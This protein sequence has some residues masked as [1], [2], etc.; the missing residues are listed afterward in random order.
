MTAPRLCRCHGKAMRF[1]GRDWRCA[2]KLVAGWR[3]RA[4]KYRQSARGQAN[5]Q[6]NRARRI[7]IGRRYV[8]RAPLVEQAAQ[9]NDH[10]RRRVLE[11]EQRFQAGAEAEGVSPG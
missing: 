4:A 2:I 1:D 5:A 11:F 10:I 7:Y 8:G 9:I 3:E 6:K